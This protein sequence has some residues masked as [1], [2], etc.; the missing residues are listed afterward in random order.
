[1]Q[2]IGNHQHGHVDADH[3]RDVEVHRQVNDECESAQCDAAEHRA[4]FRSP[5]V[6]FGST[7]HRHHADG[8]GH[9]KGHVQ[10]RRQQPVWRSEIFLGRR[11]SL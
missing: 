6:S 7:H 10:K 8:N 3:V 11:H 5:V 9:V 2:L 1:M 4:T